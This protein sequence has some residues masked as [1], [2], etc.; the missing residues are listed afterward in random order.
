M[1]SQEDNNAQSGT[2]P[3]EAPSSL[4]IHPQ[5][6]KAVRV[7][8]RAGMAIGAVIIVLML[9]FAYGGY[10]RQQRAQA[11]ARDV[12]QPRNVTPATAAASEFVKNIPAANAPT[13]RDNPH[14]IQPDAS[15]KGQQT[16]PAAS[17]SVVGAPCGY[18]PRTGQAFRFNP[19]TGQ[20]CT[21]YSPGDRVVVRQGSVPIHSSST[22]QS[23]P[24]QIP[25]LSPEEQQALAAYKREQEAILAPTSIRTGST[26]TSAFHTSGLSGG[27][28]VP[29]TGDGLAQVAALGQALLGKG[30]ERVSVSSRSRQSASGGDGEY[31]GQNPQTR[32]ADFLADARSE[33]TD[34]YL[35]STRTPPLG[36][37]EVKAGWEIP[38][39]LEQA[40]NSD[41]PGEIKALV[42]ENVYDTATGRFL[43]IPQGSRLIGRYDSEVVYGQDGVQV[44]WSRVVFP[45]ASSVDLDGMVGMDAQ[46]NA[47]LRHKVDRHYRRLF[48]FAALTSLF[49]A[50][51]EI[52]Q[53][54]NQSVLIAP[55]SSQT[56]SAAVGREMSQTG[57]SITRR[58]L[59]V[60]PT[61]KVPA[62]YKFSVRV[63]RDILFEAP[64][65]PLLADPQPLVPGERG[66]RKRAS[67]Q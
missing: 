5:P 33:K 32:K 17:P 13:A 2:K 31:D 35:R 21:G 25:Q 60:Q 64:Y 20:P 26:S 54:R 51:F 19:Q 23:P 56:A 50:A 12:G 37:F 38:A 62:G 44:V 58:N 11:S 4:D 36:T 65:E 22:A 10:Q 9:A 40:L 53:R 41:L 46:G 48:G 27:S 67:A 49:T 1:N 14:A 45:D 8:R 29:N 3:I 61:I 34:S 57:A 52:S 63:N 59:N 24:V 6:Q 18:D 16:G 39:V 28:Q 42:R 30:S 43:L 55:S 15:P 47:G 66:L 7:S